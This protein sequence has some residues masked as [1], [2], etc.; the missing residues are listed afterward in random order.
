MPGRFT[1]RS[2]RLQGHYSPPFWN[3]ASADATS[4]TREHDLDAQVAGCDR[5]GLCGGQ[6]QLIQDVARSRVPPS[7]PGRRLI[8]GNDLPLMG[9][10][11]DEG[12]IS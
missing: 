8:G 6:V 4:E 2:Q 9:G 5:D 11:V 12:R 3:T 10:E 1:P 7:Y